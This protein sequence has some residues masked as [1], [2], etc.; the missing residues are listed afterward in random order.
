MVGG[1]GGGM[2]ERMLNSR[3]SCSCWKAVDLIIIQSVELHCGG[4][5]KIRDT[6]LFLSSLY[7][8]IHQ[9]TIV[10]NVL[11]GERMGTSLLC[12]STAGCCIKM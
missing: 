10:C 5:L 3:S 1:S 9:D 7:R 2:K 8:S 6:F 4:W 11:C 12:G